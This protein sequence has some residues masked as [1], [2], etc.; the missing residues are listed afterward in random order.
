[1]GTSASRNAAKAGLIELDSMMTQQVR[2]SEYS[3]AYAILGE[4]DGKGMKVMVT[5]DN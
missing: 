4:E 3:R 2:F 1:M 5:F